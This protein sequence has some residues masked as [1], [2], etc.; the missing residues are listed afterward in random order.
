[1]EVPFILVCDAD[2]DTMTKRI[3][4]RAKTSGRSDDNL[5]TI[6]KIFAVYKAETIPVVNLFEKEGKVIHID[7]QAEVDKVFISVQKALANYISYI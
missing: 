1:M 7:A 5:E 4:E 6:K 3:L 2:E